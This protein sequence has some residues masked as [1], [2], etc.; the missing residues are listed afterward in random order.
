MRSY[1]DGR[2]FR[3]ECEERRCSK[4]CHA[5]LTKRQDNTGHHAVKKQRLRGAPQWQAVCYAS[6]VP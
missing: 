3:A 2:N 5:F 6:D 1:I 4:A